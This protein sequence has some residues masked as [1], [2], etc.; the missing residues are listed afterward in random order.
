MKPW[1]G[2]AVT[3]ARRLARTPAP[4][5]NRALL[6][7]A[8]A[9][10]LKQSELL[11][12]NEMDY[13]A[14]KSGGMGAAMLDRLQLTSERILGMARDL[15]QVAALPDPVGETIDVAALPNGMSA[16]RRRVPLGVIGS[17][18]ESRPNVTIDIAGLCLKSGN[19]CI[20]RGGAG[21]LELQPCPLRPGE[22]GH[23]RGRPTRR[24][25]AVRG[26]PGPRPG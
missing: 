5:K 2:A 15:R 7:V 11:V 22:G 26:Q 24:R 14:A 13:R 1:A 4:V 9:L 8:D 12:R 10:E 19:A 16:A 18:Y 20:L 6:N 21:K 23:C 17:I 25:R 3:A